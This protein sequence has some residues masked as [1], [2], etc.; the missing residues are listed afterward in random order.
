MSILPATSSRRRLSFSRIS[1]MDC[2]RFKSACDD[3]VSLAVVPAAAAVLVELVFV[4]NIF[5]TRGGIAG[6]SVAGN[7]EEDDGE[8]AFAFKLV[9][10]DEDGGENWEFESMSEL[11]HA[12]EFGAFSLVCKICDGGDMGC[13]LSGD[14][15]SS[16]DPLFYF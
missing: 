4:D 15:F 5:V 12:T 14:L 8:K 13:V 2:T 16:I 1:C 7:D 11:V 9:T 6:V 3:A 10:V